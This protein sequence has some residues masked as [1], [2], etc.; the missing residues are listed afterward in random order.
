MASEFRPT[1]P[2]PQAGLSLAPLRSIFTLRPGAH[3]VQPPE[4]GA[5]AATRSPTSRLTLLGLGLGVAVVGA[6]CVAWFWAGKPPSKRTAEVPAVYVNGAPREKVTGHGKAQRWA[7]VPVTV[8]IDSSVEALGPGALAAVQSG[9]GAWIAS[10]ASLPDL[11]FDTTSGLTPKLE[12]DGVNAIIVAPIEFK[13]HKQDLALTI[14]FVDDKTG[15]IRESDIIINSKKAL[16]VV[17]GGDEA[18]CQ[19]S[20]DLQSVLAHEA[21][22]FFGLGEDHDE[23]ATTM[24]YKTGKCDLGKRDLE[25]PDRTVMTQ[26]YEKAAPEADA[27]EDVGGGCGGATIARRGPAGTGTLGVIGMLLAGAVALGTRRRR[28]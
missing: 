25:L 9:F 10:D 7:K 8:K 19:D 21:G 23:V 22:H 15:R 11:S 14:S 17:A 3:T 27:D 5:T 24:F 13:G 2:A 4:E 28:R 6:G 20:Y 1:I 12:P 16:A 26:L 18:G